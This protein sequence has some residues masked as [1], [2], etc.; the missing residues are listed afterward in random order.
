[1]VLPIFSGTVCRPAALGVLGTNKLRRPYGSLPKKRENPG[2]FSID[3]AGG[4]NQLNLVLF[5]R[6]YRAHILT[7]GAP[8]EV[9]VRTLPPGLSF[10]GP[11][12]ITIY[13]HLQAAYR[14]AVRPHPSRGP[15]DRTAVV[16]DSE[17][18]G[19]ISSGEHASIGFESLSASLD[20]CTR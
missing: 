1:M 11:W 5:L 14:C 19:G 2:V 16:T 6:S 18:F 9:T 20:P 4:R 13:V 17:A 15:T 10:D 12:R 3:E 7:Y 8:D